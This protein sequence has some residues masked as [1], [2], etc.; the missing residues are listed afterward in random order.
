MSIFN[1]R[2]PVAKSWLAL[3][4][5]PFTA[6]FEV[7]QI[8]VEGGPPAL[9]IDDFEDGD[10]VPSSSA[11]KT[12]RCETTPGPPRV[13]C[14][15]QAPG[16][17]SGLAEV[18]RFEIED[19]ANGAIDY[20]AVMLQAP[21]RLGTLDLG[22]YERLAFSAKLERLPRYRV[23]SD[24][25]GEDLADVSLFVQL[26]CH[27]VAP[28]GALPYGSWIE[29]FILVR[30]EWSSTSIALV[31]LVRPS[32][33]ANFAWRDCIASVEGLQFVLAPDLR[34][35]QAMAGTLSIDQVLL[36]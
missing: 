2:Q 5:L 28:P 26:L 35:G 11:F 27:G 22:S 23:E 10:D 9:E 6:C 25:A 36:Q 12:W 15:A 32:Y 21:A 18:I 20:P 33:V 8:A 14:S 4:S 1:E 34:D 3:C 7:R 17:E 19:P 30:P 31:E 24:P 29:S 16:F 13:S